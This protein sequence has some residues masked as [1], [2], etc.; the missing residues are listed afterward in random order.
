M[1]TDNQNNPY[2]ALWEKGGKDYSVSKGTGGRTGAVGD[3]TKAKESNIIKSTGKK[4]DG[5]KA[6]NRDDVVN[7]DDT[8]VQG[9]AAGMSA[10]GGFSGGGSYAAPSRFDRLAS[11][12]EGLYYQL[13]GEF[14]PPGYTQTLVKKGMN[15]FEIEDHERRKP[16]FTRT[17][18]Y[19]NEYMAYAKMLSN[20]M[21]TR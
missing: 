8:N 20:L 12:A 14:P 21:G 9:V 4:K 2:D 11:E 1:T 5:T 6:G 7:V 16:A 13:W 19:Q 18:T 3:A 10:G 15:I 17:E